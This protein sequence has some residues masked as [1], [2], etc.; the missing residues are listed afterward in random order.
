MFLLKHGRGVRC[1][2]V[3]FVGLCE[4]RIDGSPTTARGERGR[5]IQVGHSDVCFGGKAAPWFRLLLLP[6]HAM[7]GAMR[8]MI[9]GYSV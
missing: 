6:D 7:I 5:P 3:W 1:C 9:Q 4:S 2:G 8:A